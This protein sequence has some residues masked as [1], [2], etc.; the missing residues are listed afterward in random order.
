[1]NSYSRL[2]GGG[3]ETTGK[4]DQI[5]QGFFGKQLVDRRPGDLAGHLD[6]PPVHRDE[7]DVATL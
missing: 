5:A 1:M 3:P 2:I 7:Y 6:E 4:S